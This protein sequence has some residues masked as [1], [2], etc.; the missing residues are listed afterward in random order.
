MSIVSQLVIAYRPREWPL[1]TESVPRQQTISE[2]RNK[3]AD[4]ATQGHGE[5]TN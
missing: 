4:R 3:R 5:E 1:T 2:K